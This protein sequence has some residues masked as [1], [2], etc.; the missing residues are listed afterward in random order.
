MVNDDIMSH[1]AGYI[2]YEPQLV[3]VQW[4][5][6]IWTVNGPEVSYPLWGLV[7]PC[8]TRMTI[9]RLPDGDL[10]IHSP[11]AWTPALGEAV[12]ALGP[13]TAIIAPNTLHYSF[14]ADWVSMFPSASAFGPP[15]LAVKVPDVA[16]S[17]LDEQLLAHWRER[18]EPHVISLG[19][20]IEV[21]F[22]H[23]ASGTLIVTDLMQNFEAHRIRNP[24]VRL[25]MQL[26]GATGPNG[27]P[28][29]EIRIAG[30]RHRK[31]LKAGIRHMLAWQPSSIILSHGACYPTSGL[32]EI[33]R[34]FGINS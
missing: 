17:V 2:P 33:K 5:D 32:D 21:V 25:I 18:I 8:P 19:H 12:N 1:A 27:K 16:F 31:A 13:V 4:A 14:L 10:W 6:N 24:L 15:G 28:S 3:P 20:F 22:L 34:A 11:V 23:R 7:I 26:G 9:I 29:I 30:V